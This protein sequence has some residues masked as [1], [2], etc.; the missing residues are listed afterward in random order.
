[1]AWSERS[2]TSSTTRA[3]ASSAL[4]PSSLS[5]PLRRPHAVPLAPDAVAGTEYIASLALV[6]EPSLQA[7][8]PP[9]ATWCAGQAGVGWRSIGRSPTAISLK[10]TGGGDLRGWPILAD[11]AMILSDDADAVFFRAVARDRHPTPAC[12]ASRTHR[13][14]E[15]ALKVATARRSRNRPQERCA[16]RRASNRRVF[17]LPAGDV[18]RIDGSS[19]RPITRVAARGEWPSGGKSANPAQPDDPTRVQ[20]AALIN[21]STA[22][23]LPPR[24]LRAFLLTLFAVNDALQK[25]DAARARVLLKTFAIE[26]RGVKRAK[27]LPP[28]AAD[29]L[30]ARA[31]AAIE[32][33]SRR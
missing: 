31:E 28:A 25:D 18:M 17:A 7:T 8:G 24:V 4:R 19:L 3:T 1:M 9:R 21:E 23:P 30:I 33:C 5:S 15:S 22:L 13:G 10:N 27:R 6:Q 2:R 32:A 11:R 14:Y 16:I 20:V 29:A 26:V 12:T